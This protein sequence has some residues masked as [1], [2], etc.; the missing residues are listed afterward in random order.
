M[1]VEVCS[2]SGAFDS[3]SSSPAPCSRLLGSGLVP[4]TPPAEEEHFD[5]WWYSLEKEKKHII[6]F[7]GKIG[8]RFLLP[9]QDDGH[10]EG[11]KDQAKDYCQQ[12]HDQGLSF[13]F[14][15]WNVEKEECLNTANNKYLPILR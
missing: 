4:G 5:F 10:G 6:R 11:N 15:G 8:S 3:S 9:A 12:D 14:I 13:G 7:D 1:E 2:R